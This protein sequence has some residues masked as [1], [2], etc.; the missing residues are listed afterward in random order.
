MLIEL[1]VER[2]RFTCPGCQVSWIA[3]YDVQRVE[4]PYGDVFE[5]Y[6]LD[7]LPV[8][9]PTAP[10]AVCCSR[11]GRWTVVEL[12]ARRLVPVVHAGTATA[13]R[14]RVDPARA[15]AARGAPMLS[16]SAPP[17]PVPDRGTSPEGG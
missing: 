5:Y 2:L 16:G 9:V 8:E 3:D 10:G 11:C 6:S 12:V 17:G 4:D 15:E 7:G 1:A 14:R 13:P